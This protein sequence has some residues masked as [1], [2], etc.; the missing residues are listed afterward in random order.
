LLKINI[1]MKKITAT[2]LLAA[3]AFG[4][5]AFADIQSPPGHKWNWSRKLS[6]ALGNLAYGASEVLITWQRSNRSEGNHAAGTDMI[7]EGSKRTVVRVG[8]GIFELVTFPFPCYKSTYRP[9]YYRKEYMDPW[10]GY[11]EFSP[12]T[13]ITGHAGYSRVQN[14]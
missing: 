4:S 2:L 9:P 1:F 6:R 8:Y 7:V 11:G 13:G 14:W 3:L 12:H 10:F 5:I